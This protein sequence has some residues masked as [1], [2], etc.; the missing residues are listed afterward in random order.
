MK[1][2]IYEALF[3]LSL[4]SALGREKGASASLHLFQQITISLTSDYI[5]K[6]VA[7]PKSFEDILSV[8][9]LA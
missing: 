5:E 4:M 1:I 3:L 9:Q 6:Q 7:L 8:Q 2:I